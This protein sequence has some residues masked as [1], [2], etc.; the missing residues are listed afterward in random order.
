MISLFIIFSSLFW[1]ILL[2]LKMK[3]R[4]IISYKIENGTVCYS[5]K[6]DMDIQPWD[7]PG[8][9]QLCKSC[10]RDQS[11]NVLIGK[12]ISKY[13]LDSFLVRNWGTKFLIMSGLSII[14]Q[15]SNV[16]IHNNFVG[17]SGAL[18]L[19]M[20]HAFNY[21]HYMRISRPIKSN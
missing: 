1:L 20:V 13:T 18:L 7:A 15:L 6:E 2:H 19:F 14:L 21:Y 10:K 12:K 17:I 4:L 3:R 16:F 8:N 11:L 9:K 5:C